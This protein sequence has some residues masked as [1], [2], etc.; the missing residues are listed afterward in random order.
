MA[1]YEY[2]GLNI[3]GKNVKGVIDAPT[4]DSA[5][6]KL[7]VKGIFLE[8][9]N[10]VDRLK[11]KFSFSFSLSR[12]KSVTTLITRQL[13]FLLGASLPV[14]SAIEGVIDQ[15]EDSNVKN[16]MVDIKEK[17]REGKS[18]SEAFSEYPEYFNKMYV[19][20]VHAGEVSG[21]LDAVFERIAKMYEKNQELI[22]K[23]RASL[24]YPSVMLLFALIIIVFLI[25]FIVP[26][27]SRLFSEFGQVLPLPTR[28]LIGISKVVS[29]SW[30]A[31]IIFFCALYFIIK[32]MYSHEKWKRYF[33]S[34]ILKLP[35]IKRFIIDT[36][37]IRFSYTMSLMLANGV[38]IIEALEHT[39]GAFKNRVLQDTITN[40]ISMVKKGERLSRALSSGKIFN[41]SLLGM[42]HA[43]EIGDRVP[44]VL[45]KIGYNIET[46]LEDKVRTLT[47]LVEPV[48]ILL[49]GIVV[50]FAVLSIVL[51]IFQINQIFG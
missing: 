11:R 4:T 43:G 8:E 19:S 18:V 38:G 47:S 21:K 16:M 10:E 6:K 26:T 45:D 49:I 42:I 15:F 1:V 3:S 17:V 12:K 34:L 13:S 40:A 14:V 27:F 7:K 32:R 2:R 44:E 41:A 51:P 35:G 20:T 39:G 48:V 29:T 5:R 25:S 50:G 22:S 36:F 28:I 24:T 46:Q 33:D 23:L 37:K 31:F 9:I 30:W